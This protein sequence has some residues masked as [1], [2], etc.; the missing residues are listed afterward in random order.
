MEEILQK[1]KLSIEN[2]QLLHGKIIKSSSYGNCIVITFTDKSKYK[3]GLP[4][5][6]TTKITLDNGSK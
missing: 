6:L 3:I 4:N 5:L 2:L 1:L